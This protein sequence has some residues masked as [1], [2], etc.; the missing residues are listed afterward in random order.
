MKYNTRCLALKSPRFAFLLSRLASRVSSSPQIFILSWKRK[1][2]G[3]VQRLVSNTRQSWDV[4]SSFSCRT[5]QSRRGKNARVCRSFKKPFRPAARGQHRDF[6]LIIVTLYCSLVA[7]YMGR[8]YLPWGMTV[9]LVSN[10]SYAR[11]SNTVQSLLAMGSQLPNILELLIFL[12]F[13]PL[14]R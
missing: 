7:I 3:S 6:R 10:M 4:V 8:A 1:N 11:V 9:T 5:K 12:H 14:M 13:S 2:S